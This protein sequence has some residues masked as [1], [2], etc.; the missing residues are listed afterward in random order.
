MI[1]QKEE[2]RKLSNQEKSKLVCDILEMIED[3]MFDD[4]T[5]DISKEELEI[6]DERIELLKKNPHASKP[7]N[8]VRHGLLEIIKSKKG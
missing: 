4:N 7:W 2:I 3:E 1:L 8:E 6:V 5:S